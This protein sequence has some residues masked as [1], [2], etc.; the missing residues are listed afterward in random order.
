M[1]L[2]EYYISNLLISEISNSASISFLSKSSLQSWAKCNCPS[3]VKEYHV[4]KL[5]NAFHISRRN[6][7]IEI[8]NITGDKFSLPE[9]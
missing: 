9:R 1:Y 5:S 8:N 3:T 2:V 4:K 6:D 7:N